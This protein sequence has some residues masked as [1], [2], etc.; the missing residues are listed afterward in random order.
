M[1]FE[2]RQGAIVLVHLSFFNEDTSGLT[3]GNMILED[4]RLGMAIPT[5]FRQ[6][7]YPQV[8]RNAGHFHLS[9]FLLAGSGVL[10][11]YLRLQ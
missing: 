9:L 7:G 8:A 3:S 1:M 5:R 10:L 2:H 6:E 4:E 11:L